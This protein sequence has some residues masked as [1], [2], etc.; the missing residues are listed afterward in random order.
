VLEEYVV[1]KQTTSDKDELH[2]VTCSDE[3]FAIGAWITIWSTYKCTSESE[4]LRFHLLTTQPSAPVFAKMLTLAKRWGM[5]LSIQRATPAWLG[6][7]RLILVSCVIWRFPWVGSFAVLTHL[8]KLQNI[9][10]EI[11]EA[12]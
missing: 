4:N 6:D 7:P 2:V 3:R 1:E 10:K 8:A 11:Y 9:P 12:A 5:K